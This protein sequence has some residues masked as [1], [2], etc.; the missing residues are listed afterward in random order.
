MTTLARG[1]KLAL[2]AM[3]A[4]ILAACAA[5]QEVV[6]K[7]P[8]PLGD[9]KLGLVTVFADNVEKGPFSRE[10]TPDELAASLKAEVERVFGPY[11]GTK[12]YNIA[13]SVDAYALALPGIPLVAQ[14]KSALVVT[15]NIWDDTR[16]EKINAEPEQ[17]TILERITG[18][19]LLLGSGLT[20]TREEQLAELNK[21]AVRRIETWLRENEALFTPAATDG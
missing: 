12:F 2:F 14:P 16:A 7:A 8:E 10:A 18:G 21:L 9:F 17:F 13:L 19:S 6:D 20:L 4:L 3:A 5:P 15:L 1:T 11:P